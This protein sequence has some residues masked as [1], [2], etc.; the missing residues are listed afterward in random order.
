MTRRSISLLTTLAAQTIAL[1]ALLL[2]A[3]AIAQP[4][5][6]TSE[7]RASIY[8]F[9]P[10]V[11]GTTRFD[12]PLG[13][14][15]DVDSGTLLDNTD[16]ALMAAFEVQRN[17]FGGF[18]D[19][20]Y[21]DVGTTKSATRDLAIDGVPL[22]VTVNADATLDLQTS[23]LTMAGQVRAV[24]RPHV[25]LDLFGGARR[26]DIS[27]SL[28]WRFDS[29]V[30]PFAGPSRSGTADASGDN[31]DAIGGV[32]GRIALGASRRVYAIFYADAGAGD[33]DLTYQGLAGVGY[34]FKHCDILGAWRYV[35]YEL[36][37]DRKL[38]S[39]GLTGPAVG[40]SF[41]W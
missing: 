9:L 23:I 12:T 39:L 30:G 13:S 33:S 24:S 37:D 38:D 4:A 14:T 22:P 1:A 17:R 5:M 8:A 27:T 21:F 6:N 25:V 41:H 19:F 29:N 3:P 35:G 34:A 31:W 28:A 32:K 10:S 7:V 26:L 15:I 20:M 36:G 18:V 2:P 11:R 16:M 40:V